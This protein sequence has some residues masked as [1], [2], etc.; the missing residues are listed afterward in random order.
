MDQVDKGL[1]DDADEAGRPEPEGQ[2]GSSGSSSNACSPASEQQ[3]SAGDN[4]MT[5]AYAAQLEAELKNA[6][7]QLKLKQEEIDKLSKIRDEVRR[8][9]SYV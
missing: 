8:S 6:K 5:K 3:P 4:Q 2:T 7:N 9:D 1:S